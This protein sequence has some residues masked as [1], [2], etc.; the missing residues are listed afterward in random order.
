MV[1]VKFQLQLQF[2]L[3]L[4]LLHKVKTNLYRSTTFHR[5]TTLCLYYLK[6]FMQ[7]DATLDNHILESLERRVEEF[8]SACRDFYE[9]VR[10]RVPGRLDNLQPTQRRRIKPTLISSFGI[11]GGGIVTDEASSVLRRDTAR[12]G[13]VSRTNNIEDE[14]QL[15]SAWKTDI[16]PLIDSV[17]GCDEDWMS[18]KG[19]DGIARC[20]RATQ[21]VLECDLQEGLAVI[22]ESHSLLSSLSILRRVI[23]KHARS[24]FQLVPS[25]ASLLQSNHFF[26]CCTEEA[27]PEMFSASSL[28][29]ARQSSLGGDSGGGSDL[30][31]VPLAYDERRD[32][33]NHA[34]HQTLHAN[35]QKLRDRLLDWIRQHCYSP[36]GPRMAAEIVR[37]VYDA[38]FDWF[39]RVL[40]HEYEQLSG[41]DRSRLAKLEERL[42]SRGDNPI[43]LFVSSADSHRLVVALQEVLFDSIDE[44]ARSL[45]DGTGRQEPKC[46]S[47]LI[48][49]VA[50]GRLLTTC[51]SRQVGRYEDPVL[52]FVR[53]SIHEAWIEGHLLAVL[54]WALLWHRESQCQGLTSIILTL[55]GVRPNCCVPV[56]L[57]LDAFSMEEEVSVD[58]STG[59]FSLSSPRPAE[60][61]LGVSLDQDASVVGIERILFAVLPEFK[62]WLSQMSLINT[63]LFITA[64]PE[65]LPLPPPTVTRTLRKV[66]PITEPSPSAIQR[67]LRQWL[68]W[69]HPTLKELL[70]VLVKH[71]Q[72]RPSE[73]IA[74]LLWRVIPPLLPASL[75]DS[76]RMELLVI[77]LVME[78]VVG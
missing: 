24:I 29:W 51:T 44:L 61:V 56:R 12:V 2:R 39:A 70:D 41:R 25:Q 26:R 38:N 10:R 31:A 66:R 36:D 33:R 69:Q 45:I 35:Q 49:L 52:C 62:A 73:E 37:S 8:V 47:T 59:V 67:K 63:P 19:L 23:T 14:N 43:S 17:V 20:L 3:Q 78:G 30:D 58:T 46:S 18:I 64:S 15:W 50:L 53:D 54:P 77:A 5:S 9:T 76:P 6:G 21:T 7:S 71:L 40:L 57:L 42:T 11:V 65:Q 4:Q 28:E 16:L 55:R 74:P 60:G 27:I 22:K 48:R 34:D 1:L 32:S 75:Q 13:T 68:W 72:E